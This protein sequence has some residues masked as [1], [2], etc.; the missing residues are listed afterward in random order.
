VNAIAELFS[1]NSKFQFRE[2][3]NEKV[4]KSKDVSN[5][6]YLTLPRMELWMRLIL[7]SRIFLN[8][9]DNEDGILYCGEIYNLT[10]HANLVV[11]SACEQSWEISHRRR[12]PLAYPGLWC[13]QGLKI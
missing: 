8:S 13:M 11:L 5:Y 3:A 4:V 10:M 6:D 2:E 1:S 12:G 9:Q 7:L